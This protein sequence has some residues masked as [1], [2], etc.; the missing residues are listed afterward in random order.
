MGDF[1]RWY[2]Q[3]FLKYLGRITGVTAGPHATNIQVVGEGANDRHQFVVGENWHKCL[4][5]R[6]M[7][8]SPVRIVQQDDVAGFPGF[9]WIGS[10]E[11]CLE[12]L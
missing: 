6:Q 9:H 5:I 4:D 12:R 2:A 8:P 1:Y 7:L 10:G 11:G 3:S